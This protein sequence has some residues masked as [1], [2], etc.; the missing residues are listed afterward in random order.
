MFFDLCGVCC[1][2]DAGRG[3]RHLRLA[4]RERVLAR[5]Y[6]IPRRV[7]VG[8]GAVARAQVP[9]DRHRPASAPRSRR[10]PR[11]RTGGWRVMSSP[12][13]AARRA[14]ASV[15]RTQASAVTS[16]LAS[17][18]ARGLR[19]SCKHGRTVQP[20]RRSA[21][22]FRR[23]RSVRCEP[24]GVR[25]RWRPGCIHNPAHPPRS[26]RR[27]VARRLRGAG[28]GA[29]RAAP[30]L[31]GSG[32]GGASQ[33]ASAAG[34]GAASGR[35]GGDARPR[36][37]HAAHA[38]SL[39]GIRPAPGDGMAGFA[40]GGIS[41]VVGASVPAAASNPL[42]VPATAPPAT[43]SWKPPATLGGLG[44]QLLGGSPL[45]G[46]QQPLGVAP[47]FAPQPAGGGLGGAQFADQLFHDVAMGARATAAAYAG[48]G[49]PYGDFG[50]APPRGPPAEK[51]KRAAPGEYDPSKAPRR[52]QVAAAPPPD[53]AAAR[54]ARPRRSVPPSLPLRPRRAPRRAA[55]GAQH[56][57]GEGAAAHQEGPA[58]IRRGND[59]DGGARRLG[60][61]V[62]GG[63][64]AL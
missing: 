45:G 29:E 44:A 54:A 18:D 22:V 55:D 50:R 51:R 27:L 48:G 43:C 53:R 60:S 41:R 36:P 4:I 39:A 62:A 32:G 5:C 24:A 15:S 49:E 40:A 23:P 7:A 35:P 28:S 42:R 63:P 14:C 25:R 20:L 3:G 64:R 11:R 37:M 16:T 30:S 57:L 26:D 33:L 52:A 34:A 38:G 46:M 47:Q 61:T 1:P 59:E 10:T 12:T 21:R 2:A 13:R 8:R 6:V 31:R 56:V 58:R 19:N 17:T 9:A